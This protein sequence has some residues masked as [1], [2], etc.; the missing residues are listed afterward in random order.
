VSE[1]LAQFRRLKYGEVL[2]LS[3][4]RGVIRLPIV[5]IIV[6]YSDQQGAIIVDRSLYERYWDDDSVNFFRVYLAKGASGNEVKRLVLER[7]AG[8]RR[9]FVLNNEELK[10]YILRLATQWFALTYVQVGVAVLVAILG[11]VNSLTVSITDRRRE[12]GVLRAVGGLNGQIRRTIW[13]EALTT[14]A[15]GVALGLGLGAIN[16]YY[17]LQIIRQDIA[18]LRL[19][20]QFPV[21][22]GFAI[23]PIMLGAAFLAAIWPAESAV[24]G[25]LVEAL[26]YE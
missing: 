26:E 18:G 14:A 24:R 8:Q 12:L 11:I 1:N 23:L 4:P 22:V 13:L 9:V 2:E 15:I 19:V 21:S 3:A 25:S 10:S 20:Y 5:G 6:D 7:Y 17:V 16:L